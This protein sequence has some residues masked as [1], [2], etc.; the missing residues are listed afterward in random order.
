MRDF[1][2]EGIKSQQLTAL[3]E[4]VL[5]GSLGEK[6]EVTHSHEAFWQNVKQEATNELVRGRRGSSSFFDLGLFDPGKGHGS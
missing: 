2:Q 3:R 5:L 1:G 4:S 6:A